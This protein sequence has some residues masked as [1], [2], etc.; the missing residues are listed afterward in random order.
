MSQVNAKELKLSDL[1]REIKIALTEVQDKAHEEDI[2]KLASVELTLSVGQI[3]QAGGKFG[4]F[5]VSVGGNVAS[6][7]SGI[8][9]LKLIPPPPNTPSDVSSSN[10]SGQLVP[11]ILSGSEAIALASV[12]EPPLQPAE[13][14]A[15]M[16]FAVKSDAYAGFGIAWP[17]FS[18]SVGGAVKNSQIHKIKVTYKP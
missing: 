12:G 14:S 6:E 8:V 5:A 18:T 3:A 13:L 9:Y 16:E 15:T 1:V 2:P 10:L 17:P 4:L 7:S 11:M